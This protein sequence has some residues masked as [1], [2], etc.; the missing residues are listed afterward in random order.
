MQ[1]SFFLT[2]AWAHQLSY[3]DTICETSIG[4]SDDKVV[5]TSSE[6]ICDY[7]AYC[8]DI[9]YKVIS[10]NGFDQIRGPQLEVTNPNLEKRKYNR[11]RVVDGTWVFGGISCQTREFFLT[12]VDKRDKKT[13]MPIIQERIRP[14]SIVYSNC[15]KSYKTISQH[16]YTH[17]TVNHSYNFVDPP[18]QAHIQNIENLWWQV[19][20][21][22]PSTH[23]S[24][25]E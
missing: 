12:T 10:H 2:Y 25:D 15:W 13:L 20:R 24:S 16:G 3:K 18:T 5:T 1:R 11:S 9:C 6:I 19:K 4:V 23:S 22:L 17:Q 8:R 7:K 14:G 21:T